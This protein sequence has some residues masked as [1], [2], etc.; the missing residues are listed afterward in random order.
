MNEQSFCEF[1]VQRNRH[2]W[3]FYAVIVIFHFQ[4]VFTA[5][6]WE[7]NVLLC[8]KSLFVEKVNENAMYNKTVIEFGFVISQIIKVSI[9]VLNL[10]FASTD[11]TYLNNSGYHK[12]LFITFF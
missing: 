2:F 3:H 8:D 1:F 6:F 11:N 9:S 5:F 12:T 4:I 7:P 10:A